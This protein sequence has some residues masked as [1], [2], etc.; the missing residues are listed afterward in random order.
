MKKIIFSTCIILGIIILNSVKADAAI[1]SDVKKEA[2]YISLSASKTKEIEPN[3]AEV[4]FAVEN[5][6]DNAQKAAEAN[7]N[8]SNKIIEALK[9][10]TN[11]QTDTIK[12]TNYS[13]RPVYATSGGK[14]V[15]KNY[16]AANSVKVATKDTSKVAKFIDTAISNGANR[17]EGLS[18]SVENDNSAC[19][20]MYPQ[21][22]KELIKQANSIAAA[23]GSSVD[24]I[25]HLNASCNTDFSIS[26]G[27]F[28]AKNSISDGAVA[29]EAVTATPVESGK[30]K[31][32]VYVNADF[33]LK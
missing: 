7:N 33:Y 32:H 8:I 1:Q 21:L 9:L 6:A 15:I 18:Y 11:A 19:N 16:M 12:T 31:I 27:R 4:T 22:V 10:V 25:K 26:N 17:T 5:T 28:Y 14:R 3:Y 29:A 2:G 24:G 20:E 13:V 23:S 30:V